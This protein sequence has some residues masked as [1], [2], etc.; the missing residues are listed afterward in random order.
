MMLTMNRRFTVVDAFAAPATSP[1]VRREVTFTDCT[2]AKAPRG[3]KRKHDTIA[4]QSR[5]LTAAA[6]PDRYGE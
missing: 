1:S 6:A 4:I 5:A 2:T 3:R